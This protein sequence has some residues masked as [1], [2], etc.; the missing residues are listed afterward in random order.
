MLCSLPG[1]HKGREADVAN[2]A[3]VQLQ[4]KQLL[5]AARLRSC[6]AE[7]VE[8]RARVSGKKNRPDKI[9]LGTDG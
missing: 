8:I 2:C 9:L 7:A 4:A 3:F 6:H 1:V 5:L